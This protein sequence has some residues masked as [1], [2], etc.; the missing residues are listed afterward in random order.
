LSR[1][2]DCRRRNADRNWRDFRIL[3]VRGSTKKAA[4]QLRFPCGPTGL[5]E[6]I[7][8]QMR[9]GVPPVEHLCQILGVRESTDRGTVRRFRPGNA[10]DVSE[11]EPA[12]VLDRG[13]MKLPQ[14]SRIQHLRGPGACDPR[15]GAVCANDRG[16][17]LKHDPEKWVPV[18]RKRSCSNKRI[19]SG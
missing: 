5:M 17:Q 19:E 2:R 1:H 13:S 9:P 11:S 10:S 14:A 8:D 3:Y 4:G 16:R 6:Q 7:G 15:T 12:V 18:F